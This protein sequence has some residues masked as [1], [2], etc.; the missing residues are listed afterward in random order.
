MADFDDFPVDPF[1]HSCFNQAV[2]QGG[3]G[4]IPVAPTKSTSVAQVFLED[5]W[6]DFENAKNT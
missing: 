5:G 3:S 2:I 4:Y 6:T 1:F